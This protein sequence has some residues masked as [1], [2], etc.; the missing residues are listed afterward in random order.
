MG[1]RL[2][3]TLTGRPAPFTLEPVSL[4]IEWIPAA[5]PNEAM[6]S[7]REVRAILLHDTEGSF[8]TTIGMFQNP[9][10]QVSAHYVVSKAGRIVQ[11]VRDEDSAFH[12]K[13]TWDMLPDWLKALPDPVVCSRLN[14]YTIGIEMELWPGEYEYPDAE[15]EAVASLLAKLCDVHGL[16]YDRTHVFG[17]GEVQAD[18][19]DPRDFLWNRIGL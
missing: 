10:L 9:K 1:Q 17:H 4:A 12:A 15:Y 2:G 13:G 7:G 8:T 3:G 11:M 19:R 18:R 5:V 16:P 6:W 14:G